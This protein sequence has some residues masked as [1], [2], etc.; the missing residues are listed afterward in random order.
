MKAI[1]LG[2]ASAYSWEKISN[3]IHGNQRRKLGNG[4]GGGRGSQSNPSIANPRPT[5]LEKSIFIF[6]ILILI[7]RNEEGLQRQPIMTLG[8]G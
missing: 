4:G 3:P 2:Q 7:Y 8:G 5:R 6:M 1:H